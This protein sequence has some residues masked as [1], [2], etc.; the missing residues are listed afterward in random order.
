MK[1]KR[2]C[3]EFHRERSIYHKMKDSKMTY[4]I[5][6]LIQAAIF[7]IGNVITKFAYTS[8][9][10]FWCL[11]FRFGIAL[12]IF[13]L[14]WGK[15]MIAQLSAA[16]VSDWLP[17]GLG[18]AGAFIFS[19]VALDLTTATNVGFLMGLPVMFTPMIAAVVLKRRYRAGYI[20]VQIAVVIGLYFLCSNGG[21]FAFG[22]GEILALLTSVSSAI[23]FVYGE[24][25]LKNL[26]A[27]TISAVQTALAFL[28]TIPGILIWERNMDFAAVEPA[29]WMVVA[30]LASLCTVAAFAL[31]NVALS[32]ISASMVSL[33]LCGE[34]LFTAVLAWFTLGER[35]SFTGIIGGGVIMACM[36]AGNYLEGKYA[37]DEADGAEAS[38]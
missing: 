37:Q 19:N 10:P 30:Y 5:F 24:K 35:L 12:L 20:P 17:A 36:F 3:T 18:A 25:G 7:G 31:Q 16:R 2:N 4:Y 26:D 11:F 9:T 34:P 21:F 14:F 22:A 27:V 32:H 29:A 33:L 38:V 23:S 6:V 28:G 1:K 8:I 15:K 13:C